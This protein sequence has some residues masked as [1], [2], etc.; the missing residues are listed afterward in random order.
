MSGTRAR[1]RGDAAGLTRAEAAR[2][3]KTTKQRDRTPLPLLPAG[4]RAVDDRKPVRSATARLDK[5][6]THDDFEARVMDSDHASLPEGVPLAEREDTNLILER[7]L[8]QDALPEDAMCRIVLAETDTFELFDGLP[9]QLASGTPAAEKQVVLNEGLSTEQRAKQANPDS[10]AERPSQCLV[11]VRKTKGTQLTAR[12]TSDAGCSASEWDIALETQPSGRTSGS[13]VAARPAADLLSALD[14]GIGSPVRTTD[15]VSRE[16]ETVPESLADI[17]AVT[18]SVVVQNTLHREVFK[19]RGIDD[20]GASA[21][22]SASPPRLSPS[23]SSEDLAALESPASHRT[24][25]SSTGDSTT[26]EG[27]RLEFLWKYHC[28]DPVLAGLPATALTFNRSN[29]D[30]IAVAY[31]DALANNLAPG[32]PDSARKSALVLWSV[33]NPS[34][35]Q[36]IIPMDNVPT[37]IA[38]SSMSPTVLAVGCSD[39]EVLFF[40]LE[41]SS[42]EPVLSSRS[43]GKAPQQT[44]TRHASIV[45]SLQWVYRGEDRGECLYSTGSDGRIIEWTMKKGLGST[46]VMKLKRV[47]NVARMTNPVL[48]ARASE[49]LGLPSTGVTS[50]GD[51]FLSS[52]PGALG[53]DFSGSSIYVCGTSDGLVHKGN[54]SYNEQFLDTYQG[55]TAAVHRV[56]WSPLAEGVL[57]SCAADM[58]I[59]IW[60]TDHEVSANVA[61]GTDALPRS[62]GSTSVTLES[63]FRQVLDVD[64][65]PT[66]ATVFASVT[67]GC[68]LHLWDLTQSTLDP[69]LVLDLNEKA[70]EVS[71]D[72]EEDAPASEPAAPEAEVPA[73]PEDTSIEHD[74]QPLV[75]AFSP[76]DPVL[77]VAQRSGAIRVYRLHS[78]A[79]A[80]DGAA[81]SDAL[82]E[83]ILVSERSQ[84]K[85]SEKTPR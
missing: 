72:D 79:E 85:N 39:G 54:T 24:S 37:A 10:F 71:S 51:P 17:L 13:K 14:V 20:V 80:L 6:V 69:A 59:R 57:L 83:V 84:A 78:D 74:E 7:H 43:V 41:S 19:Y 2:R 31:A 18:E 32:A 26:A 60:D 33:K 62:S 44:V 64:W 73:P 82:R 5:L 48:A 63:G 40:D 3:E 9:H 53:I 47:Q 61:R 76:V 28:S 1:A 8:A 58:T 65:S 4:L 22:E 27:L 23:S 68:L 11:R 75:V 35:P 50:T 15:S 77:M 21:R 45:N 70:P 46:E 29:P 55:H 36:R 30:L 16:S 34:F 38:F 81:A 66:H 12:T 67:A 52:P 25:S 56:K 42:A 49:R